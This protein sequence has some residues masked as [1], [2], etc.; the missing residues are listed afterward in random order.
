MWN[1]LMLLGFSRRTI[2]AHVLHLPRAQ[3][4]SGVG[5]F[6]GLPLLLE[7]RIRRRWHSAIDQRTLLRRDR[8]LLLKARGTAANRRTRFRRTLLRWH[9]L[10]SGGRHLL[11][12]TLR[13]RLID[14]SRGGLNRLIAYGRHVLLSGLA[15]G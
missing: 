15:Y 14:F 4:T 9:R 8:S 5:A 1:R 13:A 10:A 3:R 12:A 11:D 6:N 2:L 7:V